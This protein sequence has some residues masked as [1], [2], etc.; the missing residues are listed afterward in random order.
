MS[1]DAWKTAGWILTPG[2]MLGR[3]GGMAIKKSL[4]GP[5]LPLPPPPPATPDISDM[6]A[7][8]R[9]ELRR[10]QRRKG[11]RATILSQDVEPANI[12]RKTLLGQ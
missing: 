8:Q 3:E 7:A 2:V 6:G 10:L 4:K 9:S 5:P 12:Q 11:R 1:S